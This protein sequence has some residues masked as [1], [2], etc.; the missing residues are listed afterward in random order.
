MLKV[1]RN[2]I[3]LLITLNAMPYRFLSRFDNSKSKLRHE[4]F[5]PQYKLKNFDS[6][7]F[8]DHFFMHKQCKFMILNCTD[9]IVETEF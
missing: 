3:F 8:F 9:Y 1:A 6:G 2:G 4:T 5:I 7:T